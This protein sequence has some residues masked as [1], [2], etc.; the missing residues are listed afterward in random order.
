LVLRRILV[1][2]EDFIVA[3][4]G[5]E[6]LLSYSSGQV[7]ELPVVHDFKSEFFIV[8]DRLSIPLLGAP[9]FDAFEEGTKVLIEVL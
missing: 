9:R 8:V 5:H 3:W 4:I 2:V 7:F 6:L 1:V